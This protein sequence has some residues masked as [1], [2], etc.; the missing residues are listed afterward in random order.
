MV[1]PVMLATLEAEAEESKA[2]LCK[3]SET[4]SGKQI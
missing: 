1:V 2:R 4:L 3:V